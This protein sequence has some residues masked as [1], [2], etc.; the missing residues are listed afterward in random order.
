VKQIHL[1]GNSHLSAL[2]MALDALGQPPGMNMKFVPLGAGGAEA[3]EFSFRLDNKVYFKVPAYRR[4]M[5][6]YSGQQYIE[7]NEVI[8]GVCQGYH[9]GRVY[10]NGMW[11]TYEPAGCSV[12][13]D[14]V[15]STAVLMEII[16]ADFAHI[17]N[18]LVQLKEASVRVFVISAPHP[19]AD[20][21]VITN[22]TRREIVSYIDRLYRAYVNESLADAGID[23]VLPP[24]ETYDEDGFL[25]PEFARPKPDPHHANA[26][27]GALMIK[28][29]AEFMNHPYR[30]LPDTLTSALNVPPISDSTENKVA[31]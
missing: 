20:H 11:R 2:K 15:I 8:W 4:N 25:K 17:R 13:L 27:F 18:F 3:D 12:G 5:R 1:T 16:K 30:E 24:P 10:R 31:G 9:T 28:R 6:R 21:Y 14:Q 7:S 23:V 26:A 19:R 29:I 22:G